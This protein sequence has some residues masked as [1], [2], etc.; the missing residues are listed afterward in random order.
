MA[1]RPIHRSPKVRRFLSFDLEWAKGP[2]VHSLSYGK[3]LRRPSL[4]LVGVYDGFSYRHYL[5][6]EDFLAVELTRENAGRW[7]YAHAGGLAD[8]TFVLEYLAQT[9]EY[10]VDASFSGSS[11]I[12]VH[13]TKGKQKWTFVDSLWLIKAPLAD[14]GELLGF[15]KGEDRKSTRLNSSHTDISRMPSS[16]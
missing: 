16:A 15:K 1:I 2:L 8:M 3:T 5:T 14:I 7:F 4:R 10:Q 12:I 6:I 11:A 9:D 13:V